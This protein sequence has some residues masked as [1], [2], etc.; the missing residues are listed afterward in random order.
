MFHYGGKINKKMEMFAI[1][2]KHH[3]QI[4]LIPRKTIQYYKRQHYV[5]FDVPEFYIMLKKVQR[6]FTVTELKA[7]T[8]SMR[9]Q[10]STF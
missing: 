4:Q 6:A 9:M 3:Q 2:T 1:N 7:N 10:I 5:V 8:F